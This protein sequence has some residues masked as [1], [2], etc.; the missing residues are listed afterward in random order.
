MR[1]CSVHPR[2]HGEHW[3]RSCLFASRYGSSPW[4]RGTPGGGGWSHGRSRFIPVGTGNTIAD[5]RADYETSVHP[6][7]HG[8]HMRGREWHGHLIGSSPWARGTHQQSQGGAQNTRFIPVGTGNTILSLRFYSLLAVHPR[9][10]GE[11][12]G[13][14]RQSYQHPGSSPWARGTLLLDII[15][16]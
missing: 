5:V 2:G 11:H 3:C 6:R 14:T 16:L 12:S 13:Y 7:G 1:A 4:A 10:H 8:E 9:G 15:V